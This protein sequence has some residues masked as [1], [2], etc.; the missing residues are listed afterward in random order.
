MLVL[1]DS[2]SD[3]AGPY[4]LSLASDF[5]AHLTIVAIVV[6]PTTSLGFTGGAAAFAA[7]VLDKSRDA[8]R[9]AVDEVAATARQSGVSADIELVEVGG[10]SMSD[11]LGRHL[12]YFDL[13]IM[14]QPDPEVPNGKS[15]LI[16]AALFGSGRPLLLVPYI[17]R[18]PPRWQNVTVAWD[19]SATA[20]RTAI[21]VPSSNIA[22]EVHVTAT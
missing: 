11:A 18:Q 15:S 9:A 21:S 7:T 19:G 8:A 16:E 20:A 5:Q 12:R 14:Q 17:H 3:T 2:S 10:A 1:L 13:T 6:D 4:A 22:W